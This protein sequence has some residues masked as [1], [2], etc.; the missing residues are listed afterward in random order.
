MKTCLRALLEDGKLLLPIKEGKTC[1]RGSF[2]KCS[3]TNLKKVL[4]TREH[5][6]QK[7]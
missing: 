6:N 7:C 5:V 1:E 3:V 4:L 2:M